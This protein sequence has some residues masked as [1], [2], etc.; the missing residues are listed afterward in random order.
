MALLIQCVLEQHLEPRP[1]C[2]LKLFQLSDFTQNF[3]KF[4]VFDLFYIYFEFIHCLQKPSVVCSFFNLCLILRLLHKKEV[5][6]VQSAALIS[7][8][9]LWGM[10]PK[11]NK[12]LKFKVRIL[13][14]SFGLCCFEFWL[15]DARVKTTL[16][17]VKN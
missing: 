12:R 4:M 2:L 11:F 7:S 6:R 15:F 9:A 8:A 5:Q 14:R 13:E 1:W 3:S 16:M 10:F 17:Q